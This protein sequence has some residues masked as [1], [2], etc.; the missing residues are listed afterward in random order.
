MEEREREDEGKKCSQGIVHLPSKA[1]P[2]I[3]RTTKNEIIKKNLKRFFFKLLFFI[4]LSNNCSIM[5]KLFLP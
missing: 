2:Q 1:K 5:R 3:I 4:L